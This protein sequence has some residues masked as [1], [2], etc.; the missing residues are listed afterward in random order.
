MNSYTLSFKTYTMTIQSYQR[1]TNPHYIMTMLAI[2]PP[3]GQTG[4]S[5]H[6]EEGQPG[7]APASRPH[8]P[9][10]VHRW[11]RPQYTCTPL[12]IM[13]TD[14]REAA[15]SLSE[16]SLP[17]L[18]GSG[19]VSLAEFSGKVVLVTNVATYW[20]FASQYPDMNALRDTYDGDFEILAVPSSNFFNVSYVLFNQNTPSQ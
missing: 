16:F 20:G 5:L 2:Y 1:N 11:V 9:V 13:F 7:L 18:D 14:C 6:H 10:H 19:N 12:L 15:N 17:A 3:S 4:P 8:G